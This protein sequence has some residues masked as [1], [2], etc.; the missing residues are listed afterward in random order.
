[1]INNFKID[2]LKFHP[3]V[4]PNATGRIF[5]FLSVLYNPLAFLSEADVGLY[6]I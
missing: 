5:A 6:P 3:N 4:S 1:M 2:Y